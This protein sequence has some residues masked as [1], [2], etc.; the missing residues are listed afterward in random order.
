ME[1]QFLTISELAQ[2][3]GGRLRELRIRR[4]YEQTT[5]AELAGVSDRT[6]RN[7]EHGQGA[8]IESLLRVLKALGALEGLDALVPAPPSIN[9][10]ALL[11]SQKPRQRV[12]RR[13]RKT[14]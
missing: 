1:Q 9:P 6:V 3:L 8:K 5:V 10:L 13:R 2:A 11:K 14:E 4:G 12:V 7:L